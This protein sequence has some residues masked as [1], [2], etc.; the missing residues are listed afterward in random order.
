M[1]ARLLCSLRNDPS[2][3]KALRGAE[4]VT[5]NIGINDLGHARRSYED[6]TCGGEENEGCLRA[7]VGEVEGNWDAI[8]EEILGLRST[9]DAIIRTVGL[10]YTPNVDGVFEP[11][12]AE[13]NRHISAS[14]ADEGVPYAEVRLGEGGMSP[15]GLAPRGRGPRRDRRPAA[16]ARVRTLGLP[17]IDHSTVGW[18]RVTRCSP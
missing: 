3:R 7:A 11:Y 9:D 13:V 17:P 18:D 12:L 4:V 1:G 2:T 8:T 15:D 5:F 6:D 16:G 10:G 14:A